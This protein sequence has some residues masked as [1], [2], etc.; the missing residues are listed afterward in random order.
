MSSQSPDQIA[1]FFGASFDGAAA[2]TGTSGTSG[3][4]DALPPNYNVAPTHEVYGVVEGADGHREVQVFHWGLVPTWAKDI[5]I[6]SKMINAR[7]ETLAEKPAFKGV[8]RRHRLILPMD[9]FYEWQQQAVIDSLLPKLPA[10]GKPVK[11]PMFIFRTDGDPLAVAGLW[12]T[13]RDRAAGADAP[14]LHSCT[15]ITTSANGTMAP[16][17]DRMPVL[18]DPDN[19]DEWLDPSNA[20]LQALQRLLV[21]AADDVLT[22]HPVSTSVN[23]VRNK[24]SELIDVVSPAL[25]T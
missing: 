22:M 2:D 8:F 25:P 17:H 12:T 23:N 10:T 4:V 20:D 7:S 19:W 15:I 11:Q 6:A 14:W 21:P 1:A 18:L 24:G 9:G 3:P 13:W 5:K 16:V